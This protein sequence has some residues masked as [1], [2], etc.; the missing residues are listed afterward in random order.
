[1][2]A[3][4]FRASALGQSSHPRSRPYTDQCCSSKATG[5]GAGLGEH[6]CDGAADRVA[7]RCG[8]FGTR[9]QPFSDR[10]PGQ[11]FRRA[12][13]HQALLDTVAVGA[14]GF[15]TGYDCA[16]NLWSAQCALDAISLG[17]GGA[18]ALSDLKAIAIAERTAKIF[19]VTALGTG[20]TSLLW[21]PKREGGEASKP[22]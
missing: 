2:S 15:A 4:Q 13:G 10:C 9:L 18:G 21:P 19:N 3:D 6:H 1:M 22:W 12:G 11:R 5:S 20:L 8:R 14:G 17:F 16:E 7:E